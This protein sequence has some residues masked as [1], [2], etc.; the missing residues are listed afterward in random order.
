MIT[1]ILHIRL[2]DIHASRSVRGQTT[3]MRRRVGCKCA[4]HVSGVLRQS[5]TTGPEQK[6]Q[7]NLN[8]ADTH[9]WLAPRYYPPVKNDGGACE[10]NQ[11]FPSHR[12]VEMSTT[13]DLMVLRRCPCAAAEKLKTSGS[14]KYGLVYFNMT[15]FDQR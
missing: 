5:K 9:A 4:P 6:P 15:S 12:D 14:R 7:N 1:M 8:K 13:V 10:D 11:D 3:P 2:P